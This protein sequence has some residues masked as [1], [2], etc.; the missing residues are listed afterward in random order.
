MAKDFLISSSTLANGRTAHFGR[1]AGSDEPRFLIGYK[2]SYEGNFGLF[3]TVTNEKCMYYPK[4]YAEEKGFWA[5]FIYPTAKAES[6]GSFFCLNSYDRARFTFGFMQYAAHVP[7]G[8]FV[9]FF[10]S[11]LELPNAP[12]YF[13]RLILQ[14]GHIF[15]TNNPGTFFQLED[16]TSTVKLMDY[17]NPSLM[18]IEHQEQIC[19]ARMVHWAMNDPVHRKI[20]VDSAIDLFRNQMIA[21]N[22]RFNLDKAPAKVCQLVCDIRHQG[23]G[24]NDDIASA[25]NTYGNWDKAYANL[26]LIGLPNYKCRIDTVKNTISAFLSDGVFNKIYDSQQNIFV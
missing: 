17:L 8:D 20:Q 18:E 19:S 24:M 21:C 2:T 5:Y 25:L 13:P 11:L 6:R 12:D 16:N 15:Y 22:K 4:D 9:M 10:K 3:N 1:L 7:D 23:R 26:L 14:D